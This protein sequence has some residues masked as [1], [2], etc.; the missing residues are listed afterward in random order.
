MTVEM[1]MQRSDLARQ[2]Q[3]DVQRE[4]DAAL[5]AA[6]GGPTPPPPGG[7]PLDQAIKILEAQIAGTK[8][9]I[10]ALTQQL[11]QGISAARESAITDQIESATDRLE[12]QQDQ[13]GRLITGDAGRAEVEVQPPIDQIPPQAVTI[14]I[15][16]FA[17]CAV[18]I[19][20]IPVIRAWSRWLDRRGQAQAPEVDGRLDRIEQ[21]IEAVAIEVERVSEGQRFTNRLMGDLHKIPVGVLQG[22]MQGREPVAVPRSQEG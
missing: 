3:R 10:T 8:Q 4:V 14:S 18:T 22:S 2:I 13:L 11:T 19:I 7:L 12:T 21:A 5:A 20:A 1:T 17:A 6:Q 9:E 16:F 15:A